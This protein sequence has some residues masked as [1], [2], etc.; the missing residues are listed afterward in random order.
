MRFPILLVFACTVSTPSLE[1]QI[2]HVHFLDAS[3][4]MN[5]ILGPR[6]SPPRAQLGRAIEAIPKEL[7]SDSIRGVHV[8][9][10][11]TSQ[12][13]L[14]GGSWSPAA[15]ARFIRDQLPSSGDTD[16]VKVLEAGTQAAESNAGGITFVWVLTDNVNDPRGQGADARNTREFYGHLFRQPSL[17]RRVYFFPLRDVRVVLYVLVLSGE[18]GIAKLDLDR[19][20]NA[21][22]TYGRA[23]SA[24]R[25]RAKPVGGEQPIEIDRRITFEGLDEDIRAEVVGQ[26]RRAILR[27]GGLKEGEPLRGTFRVRLRSRFNEWRIADAKV[28]DT[29]LRGLTSDD[30]PNISGRMSARL[31]PSA[32]TIDPRSLSAVRYALELGTSGDAPVPKARFFTGAAFN[33]EGVGLIRGQLALRVEE[34]KLA[35]KIFNDPAATEAI[36]SVF[37]LRDI[38]YFVPRER[39]ADELR[40]DFT[41]P[42]EFEVGYVHWTRWLA[43]AVPIVALAL[44][45]VFLISGGKRRAYLRLEGYSA[46]PLLIEAGK[47]LVIAPGGQTLARLELTRTGR[48]V[49]RPNGNATINGRR[50]AATITPGG[51]IVIESQGAEYRYRAELVKTAAT[52]PKP[53]GSGGMY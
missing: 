2:S 33:P 32:V 12:I 11:A 29:T 27:V 52:A 1:G 20:E 25:I 31:T 7:N 30:F 26:G 44:A 51:M 8:F 24:P 6:G 43:L 28:K 9:N 45:S 38:E 39:Q 15:I 46:Q 36:Q 50:D 35:L 42:V 17:V 49:C 13:P 16:L 10:T 23:I 48:L 21:M 40:L 53:G 4:S 37:Q 22:E 19:L 41:L 18:A 47:P 5:R 3:G 34:V 14:P